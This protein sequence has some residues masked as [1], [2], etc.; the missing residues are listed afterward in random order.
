MF[1]YCGNNPGIRS[2]SGG[3]ISQVCLDDQFNEMSMPWQDGPLGGGSGYTPYSSS[4][5]SGPANPWITQ[6]IYDYI[7]NSD[8]DVILSS[9]YSAFYKG[10]L[11]VRLP[12]GTDAFSLGP[13]ICLGNDVSSQE[14][15]RHEYGHSVHYSI[16]GPDKYFRYVFVPSLIGYWSGVS[17]GEYYSQPWEYTADILGQADRKDYTYSAVGEDTFYWYFAWTYFA[18][19]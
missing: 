12:I 17:Y 19:F 1:A 16:I 7:T 4:R 18:P 6:M 3:S 14:T 10:I 15:V 9:Q 2:D 13:I 5:F 8:E 11:V